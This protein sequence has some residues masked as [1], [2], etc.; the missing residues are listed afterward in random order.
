[1]LR[2]PTIILLALVALSTTPHIARAQTVGPQA[3][4][5][6]MQTAMQEEARTQAQAESWTAERRQLLNEQRELKHYD[7]WLD[8]QQDKYRA[9][10]K[11]REKAVALLEKR[12]Q[13]AER[14]RLL[15]EPL[16]DDSLNQLARMVD[17]DLPFLA[18][19]R[20]ERLNTVRAVLDNYKAPL[21]EKLRRLLE[22]LF[23]EAQYGSENTVAETVISAQNVDIQGRTLRLGRLAQF[24]LARDGQRAFGLDPASGKWTALGPEATESLTAA[25]DMAQR[26]RPASLVLL[27]RPNQEREGSQ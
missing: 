27:P 23:I 10:I 16:L 8:H 26:Q 12:K 1:M 6:E 2:I 4:L 7:L 17:N 15:L 14:I 22:T 9:Y 20:Q 5:N 24:F 21:G 3:V 13:E 18:E 19:E 11:E 25:L